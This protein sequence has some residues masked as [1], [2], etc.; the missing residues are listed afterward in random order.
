MIYE[1]GKIET[2]ESYRDFNIV[3]EHNMNIFEKTTESDYPIFTICGLGRM[4]QGPIEEVR[5][6][7]DDMIEKY[8]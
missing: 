4:Y 2:V 8:S 5:K 3:I 1:F 6:F 7:I